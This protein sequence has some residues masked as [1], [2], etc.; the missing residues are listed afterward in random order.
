MSQDQRVKY[1]AHMKN[2]LV[3][4]ALAGSL[5][6][7]SRI[8][9]KYVYPVN[10]PRAG[11]IEID[12]GLMS[13]DL[14][15]ALD[16]MTIR[17]LI[18]WQF[19]GQPVVYSPPG[20]RCV[21]IEAGWPQ[22]LSESDIPLFSIGTYPRKPN[23]FIVGK[24]ELGSAIVTSF[25]DDK[26]SALMGGSPGGGKSWA[27]RSMLAQLSGAVWGRE[28]P[29]Q[30]VLIDGKR[31]E[32]LGPVSSLP[33][34]VGPL[35]M[36]EI[37]AVDALGWAY[38]E[39]I[40]RYD[41]HYPD[42]TQEE[43]DRLGRIYVIVDEFYSF[44]DSAN[45]ISLCRDLSAQGRAA[46]VHL[47]M[48]THHPTVSVMRDAVLKNTL[49]MRI[50]LRVTSYKASEV[51]FGASDP[52]ADYLQGKGDS[53]VA[54]PSSVQRVQWAYVPKDKLQAIQGAQHPLSR[55][56]AFEGQTRMIDNQRF[57]PDQVAITMVHLMQR[58]GRPSLQDILG[59]GG[60]KTGDLMEYAK[61]ILIK[62]YSMGWVLKNG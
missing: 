16:E 8:E 52:R 19:V 32:G 62:A 35:A 61:A 30:F 2:R 4:T 6:K 58:K 41:T 17:Q 36:D 14:F 49:V 27:V 11:G 28:S 29:N 9:L 53:Y 10:G 34:V 26:P 18:P 25:D 3:N 55:W 21:R 59:T 54:V 48:I 15:R 24:N 43:K 22:D 44:R 42:W 13:R 5:I 46:G 40:S 39:M 51:I 37:E 38:S 50:G 7:G 23:S 60:S 20:S 47:I 12:A 1:L 31:G 57:S 45:F 56:P 33:G